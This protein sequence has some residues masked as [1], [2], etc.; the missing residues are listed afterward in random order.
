M[1]VLPCALFAAVLVGAPLP[2][3]PADADYVGVRTCTKCH[4]V[5]GDSWA[6]TAHAKAFESL[7]AGTKPEAKT[8][9]KLDPAKDYTKDKDCLGCHTTGFGMP[10]GYE[11]G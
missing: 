6:T 1:R 2:A 5:H 7:Q 4:D 10:G 8:K 11:V 3:L 9:A